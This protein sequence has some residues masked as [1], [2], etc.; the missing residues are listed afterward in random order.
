MSSNVPGDPE[1]I[2]GDVRRHAARIPERRHWFWVTA[3][4]LFLAIALFTVWVGF[5]LC[6]AS[7]ANKVDNLGQL[8]PPLIAASACGWAARRTPGTR[9]AWA[10]LGASSLSWAI[11]QAVWCYYD[12]LRRVVVPFP[13]LADAGY[14]TAVPLAVLGLL[15]FPSALRRVASR[16]GALLDGILISGSLLFV[17]WSTVL[18]PIY[19]SHQGGILKQVLSMA[20]PASDVVL[21]SLVVVLAMHT[22]RR[23]RAGL[24]MVMIGIVAFAISD[25]SFEYFTET[26]SYG[27]GNILDTGWVVGYLLIGLGALGHWALR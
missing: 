15:A 5:D 19:R 2:L 26:N 16:V 21:V 12:L 6:G 20:Y 9:M 7:T 14:L 8:L 27:I 10:F 25:S 3:G 13:S 1:G 23:H 24:N 18:G 17:S 4:C 11:G 22:E